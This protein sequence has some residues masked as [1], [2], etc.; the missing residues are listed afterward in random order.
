MTKP[1]SLRDHHAAGHRV[2]LFDIDKIL[3][4]RL[5]INAVAVSTPFLDPEKDLEGYT[6]SARSP[7]K[8]TSTFYPSRQAFSA[9]SYL[10]C[11]QPVRYQAVARIST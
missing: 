6:A 4:G 11:R 8:K 5:S 3:V 9:R 7:N 10:I 2:I 1:F